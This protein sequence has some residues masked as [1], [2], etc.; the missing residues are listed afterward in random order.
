MLDNF[1]QTPDTPIFKTTRYRWAIVSAMMG[2]ICFNTVTAISLTS[3]STDIATAF[4]I[5]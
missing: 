5:K 1:D 2:C 3:A 4:G